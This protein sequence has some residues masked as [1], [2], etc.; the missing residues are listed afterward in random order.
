MEYQSIG[1]RFAALLLDWMLIGLFYLLSALVAMD[2][3]MG[4]T[5][6]LAKLIF[7][8]KLFFLLLLGVI[9]FYYVV[10]EAFFGWTL[11]KRVL[12]LE[13]VREDGSPC[14]LL[15]SLIRNIFRIV[16]WLPVGNLL[17]VGLIWTSPLKQRLGD[18]LAHTVVIK[19]REEAEQVI[20]NR[21]N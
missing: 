13:V 1:T 8:I 7:L 15:C 20:E 3:S 17:G 21:A 4:P 5:Y 9:F 2:F 10:M 6:E 16:D 14:R 18:R 19:M 11:G 12:R